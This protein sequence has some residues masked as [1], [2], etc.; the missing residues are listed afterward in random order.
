MFARGLLSIIHPFINLHVNNMRIMSMHKALRSR[1]AQSA[2]FWN[3]SC[4]NGDRWL[5]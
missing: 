5:A 3:G 4:V 1:M 2:N